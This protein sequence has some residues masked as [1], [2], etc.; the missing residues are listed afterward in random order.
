MNLDASCVTKQPKFRPMKQCH[1]KNEEREESPVS[2]NRAQFKMSRTF[3]AYVDG[4]C[5]SNRCLM[6][7]AI[8]FS[9]VKLAMAS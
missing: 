6:E 7:A 8:S 5:C 1:L 4:Y 9:V 3:R 2:H